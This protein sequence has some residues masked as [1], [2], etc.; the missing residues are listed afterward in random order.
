M[1]NQL[2]RAAVVGAIVGFLGFGGISL[3]QAQTPTTKAPTTRPSSP[4]PSDGPG[5]H[6]GYAKDDPNCPNMGGPGGGGKAPAP[7][8]SSSS[9]SSSSSGQNL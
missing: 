1:K 9:S 7:S 2:T 6:P 5:K 4:S 3:A 8:T